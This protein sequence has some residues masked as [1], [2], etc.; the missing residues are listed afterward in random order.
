MIAVA[1]RWSRRRKQNMW[2]ASITKEQIRGFCG[3][4]HDWQE[5]LYAALFF[6]VINETLVPRYEILI[7]K[8]FQS[9]KTQRKVQEYLEYLFGT[10]NSGKIEIEKPKISFQTTR[11]KYVD[12][13]DQKTKLARKG[14]MRIHENKAKL[15]WLIKLLI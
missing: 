4:S 13:A 8:E 7:D 9:R 2:I 3:K 14:K 11:N 15:D 1:T 6:K 5:K 12:R 10:I